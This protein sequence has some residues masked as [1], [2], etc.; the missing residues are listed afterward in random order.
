MRGT[1]PDCGS[2]KIVPEVPL[3]DHFGDVGGFSKPASVAVHGQPDAWF[4]KDTTLATLAADV[5][6]NCGFV[7]FRAGNFRELYAKFLKSR[8][9]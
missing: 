2:Q 4:F 6:G 7:V 9:V 8:G 3:L 1:C 5:C